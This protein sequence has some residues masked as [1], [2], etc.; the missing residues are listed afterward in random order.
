MLNNDTK[1]TQKDKKHYDL[2]IKPCTV[3]ILSAKFDFACEQTTKIHKTTIK[4]L[5]NVC[6]NLRGA[7]ICR[8]DDISSLLL[9]KQPSFFNAYT[10]A[11]VHGSEMEFYKFYAKLI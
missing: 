1:F 7:F 8:K 2:I 5:W 9:F 6:F 10:A 3:K 11:V 4:W